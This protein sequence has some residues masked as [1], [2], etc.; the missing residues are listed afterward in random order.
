MRRGLLALLA[1]TAMASPAFA[2]DLPQ[3][4]AP[5]YVPPPLFTWTGAYVGANAA[6]G[7]GRY[8]YGGGS[9]FGDAGG[10]LFGITGGYNY[11]SGPVVAGVEADLAFGAVNGSGNP[12]AG[13]SATGSI[14]GE[15]SLRARFG[16]ALD[17]TLFY[18]TGGYT[19]ADLK[20]S[21]SD[22]ASNPNILASQSAYLNGF[23]IGTGVEFAL[24]RN[25]S[26]KAEY[27][28]SDYASSGLFNGTIDN[29]NSGLG[30]S[31]VRAGINY[32]F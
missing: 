4:E 16:Y 26:V 1:S 13:V 19:G 15:G 24:T 23:V 2:A 12:R 6:Y 20:G 5:Y 8:T 21:V 10:G 7:V 29:I 14:N 9:Y 22:Y 11:Q 31:T 17:H 32:R 25:I 18:I 3:S 27:L 28:F 30:V